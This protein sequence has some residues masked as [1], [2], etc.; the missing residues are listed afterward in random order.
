M[1]TSAF[2]P[3]SPYSEKSVIQIFAD[4]VILTLATD[5]TRSVLNLKNVLQTA[6]RKIMGL[7]KKNSKAGD[8]FGLKAELFQRYKVFYVQPVGSLMSVLLCELLCF[9]S[10]FY[11]LSIHWMTVEPEM[12]LQK[13]LLFIHTFIDTMVVYSSRFWKPHQVRNAIHPL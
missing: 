12:Y 3:F 2:H 4:E 5:N 10:F 11:V 13:V 9:T 6:G 1:I 8:V 7:L